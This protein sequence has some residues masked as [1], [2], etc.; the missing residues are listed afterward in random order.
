MII[1]PQVCG[2]SDKPTVAIVGL[3]YVGLPLAIEFS[4]CFSTIGFDLSASRVSSLRAGDVSTSDLSSDYFRSYNKI[5]F[6]SNPNDLRIADFIIVAVP[7]PVDAAKRPD[8]RPLVHASNTV[9]QNMKL[10]AVVVFESTVYPGA[11]EEVCIP[12]LERSSGRRWK[13]DFFISYSPE[14]INPGDAE[15]TLTRIVK[16]VSGDTPETLDRVSKLYESIISAGVYRAVSIRVAEAA[17]V[18]ENTQRDLN[19]ALVNEFAL[20]FKKLGLD[21][22]DILDTAGTKWN[23]LPFRPGLVG[24]HC[25]GVDPY[26]LTY[27]ASMEGYHPEVILAGRRINDRMGQYVAEQTIKQLILAKRNICGASVILL[28]I[29]FKEDLGDVRNS[30]AMDVVCELRNFGV[31]VYVHDPIVRGHDAHDEYGEKLIEWDD[32]P[33]ADAMI[34]AVAHSD[35]LNRPLTDL[36]NKILPGGCFIDVKS[37]FN[38]DHLSAFKVNVWRL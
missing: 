13:Q 31:N 9:G 24:G 3:G 22:Q 26:Y 10:G 21:T 27:K 34:V 7:T 37:R 2:N 1:S 23:F 4:K 35:Y 38:R 14:R 12:E 20:V 25:I 33:T 15:H 8:L 6:T 11:T 32:L 17:K 18:I 16:V 28:G 5:H 19:V 36:M 29:A 30:R